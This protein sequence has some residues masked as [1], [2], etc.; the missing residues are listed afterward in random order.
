MWWKKRSGAK[1]RWLKRS[2]SRG[3]MECSPDNSSTPSLEG[4]VSEL[5]TADPGESH[6]LVGGGALQNK[7]HAIPAPPISIMDSDISMDIMD[8]KK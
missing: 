3:R 1:E 6:P 7:A 8:S 5:V 2:S 4:A